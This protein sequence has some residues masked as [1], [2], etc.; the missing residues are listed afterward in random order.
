M[1]PSPPAGLPTEFLQKFGRNVTSLRALR[2]LACANRRLNAIFDPNLYLADA[3]RPPSAAIAW[4]AENG[5]IE[6]LQKP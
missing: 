3:R 6:I 5:S 4:A 1:I 2:A